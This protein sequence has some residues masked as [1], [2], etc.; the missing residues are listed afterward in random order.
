MLF[1]FVEAAMGS[2]GHLPGSFWLPCGF[3]GSQTTSTLRNADSMIAMPCLTLRW[4]SSVPLCLC[5]EKPTTLIVRITESVCADGI[6][7]AF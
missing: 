4:M 3:Y 5:G 7:V 6:L 1:D 2:D